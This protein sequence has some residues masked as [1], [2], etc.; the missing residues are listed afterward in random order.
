MLKIISMTVRII[1][2]VRMMLT[3]MILTFINLGLVSDHGHE[4]MIMIIT[5]YQS[6]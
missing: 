1:M 2:I 6:G 5:D 3:M 4:M